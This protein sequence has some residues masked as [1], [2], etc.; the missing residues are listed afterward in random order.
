[1]KICRSSPAQVNLS[2]LTFAT[3]FVAMYLF[4]KVKGSR[5]MTH[6][7]LTVDLIATA[8]EKGGFIDTKMFKTAG[9]YGFDSLIPTDANMQVLSGYILYVRPLLKPRCNFVVVNRNRGQH[10][11][12]GEIINKLVFDAI[13]KYIHLTRYHQI[14]ETQS[15]NELT[16]EKQR[17]FSEDQKHSSADAKVHYQKQRSREVAVKVHECLQKLQGVKG[18]EV[19]EDVHA[20]SEIHLLTPGLQLKECKM[21]TPPLK[22]TPCLNESC[23]LRETFVMF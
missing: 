18:S 1:M 14:V 17:I 10:G 7:Y 16:S 8:K 21:S 6:Q 19:D 3:R 5:P 4:I 23:A 15:L 20:R 13:G 11:K 22:R 9:K 2:K 12:L